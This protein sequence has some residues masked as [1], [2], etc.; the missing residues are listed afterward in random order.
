M[1]KPTIHRHDWVVVY[2]GRKAVIFE[3]LRDEQSLNLR[4]Q[5]VR[6][7]PN[8]PTHAQGPNVSGGGQPSVGTAGS[9]VDQTDWHDAVEQVIR[10]GPAEQLAR[11]ARRDPP[12]DR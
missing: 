9:A 3:N 5:A 4:M 12:G 8:A 7:H 10:H 1:G 2:D 6:E 11:V